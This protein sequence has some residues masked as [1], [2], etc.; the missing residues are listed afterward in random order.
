[1]PES[2]HDARVADSAAQLGTEGADEVSIKAVIA[3]DRGLPALY[4]RMKAAT[5]PY[6][7][8]HTP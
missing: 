3:P 2:D 6:N 5:K 1:M 4:E 7:H 8:G